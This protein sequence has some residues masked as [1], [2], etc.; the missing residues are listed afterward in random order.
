MRLHPSNKRDCDLINDEKATFEFSP[1]VQSCM[2]L[3][4]I[5]IGVRWV[6][7]FVTT[8]V[9]WIIDGGVWSVGGFLD[10]PGASTTRSMVKLFV[11]P[12]SSMVAVV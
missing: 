2:F 7:S 4:G 9:V 10:L 6:Y 12:C 11:M 1:T 8:F 3:I 5:A